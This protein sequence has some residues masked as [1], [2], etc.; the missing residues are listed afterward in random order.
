MATISTNNFNRNSPWWWKRIETV[1]MSL[2]MGAIPFVGYSDMV[3][4]DIK[5]EICVV[6]LPG[7]AWLTKMIGVALGDSPPVDDQK[8]NQP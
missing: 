8:P 6:W 3:P 7:L 2:F 5:K 4:P 1:L